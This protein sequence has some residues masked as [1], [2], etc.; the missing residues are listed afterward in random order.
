MSARNGSSE[1]RQ[2]WT[3]FTNKRQAGKWGG[4]N[5]ERNDARKRTDRWIHACMGVLT[6]VGLQKI[7]E[8]RE[9]CFGHSSVCRGLKTEPQH[10]DS[11]SKVILS[12]FCLPFPFFC[13]R[14]NRF[15]G[16]SCAVVYAARQREK[17]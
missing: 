15:F 2:G 7:I 6:D 12:F 14:S 8:G 10:S 3:S 16:L 17:M 9:E 13:D 1:D 11:S 4:T 5:N